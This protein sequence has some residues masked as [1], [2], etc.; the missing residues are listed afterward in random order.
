MELK[1]ENILITGGAGFIGSALALRL[2]AEGHVVTV[3]D[4][5]SP[6]IHSADP[7][8]SF[9]YRRIRDKVRFIQ[10]DIR[11]A[12]RLREAL[13]GQGII[14]HLA[15]ET[16]TGQSMY[17]IERYVDVNIRGTS[18]LLDLLGNAKN[19]VRKVI[20]SS[21]RSVYGEGKYLCAMHG[22]VYPASRREPDLSAGNFEC[23]CPVC[24]HPVTLLATDEDTH[25]DPVSVY[26]LTKL[27]Q[28]DLVKLVCKNLHIPYTI[29]RFQNVYG[30]GQSLSNPYTGILSIFSNLVRAG[31]TLNIFEDGLESRDFV[32]IDD[33]VESLYL[34]IINKNADN[35]TFNVGSGTALNVLEV[36][37]ALAQALG[38]ELSYEVTGDFRIGDI[39]HNFADLSRISAA[40]GY[41]PRTD[42][43]QGIAQF[44]S[45]I[46]NSEAGK[47]LYTE[48]LDEMQRKGMFVRKN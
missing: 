18:L 31:Q 45:W 2:R 29:L 42:F 44:T 28:E 9:T 27:H 47:S 1:P 41:V 48:S 4:N 43:Q 33:I 26:G 13:D 38:E 14:V 12:E 40:L 11:D 36:S 8:N 24:D 17:E 37:A 3:L 5:L 25:K 20:L 23:S 16:G 6:Q 10:G 46:Q 15:S 30:V 21:S 35:A 19:K 7:E 39:R 34:A 22:V 32:Y